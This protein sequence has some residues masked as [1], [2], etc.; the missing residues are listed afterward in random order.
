LSRLLIVLGCGML[1]WQVGS[2]FEPHA[3]Q[4][5]V[6]VHQPMVDFAF[7]PPEVVVPTGATVVWPNHGATIH[8]VAPVDLD[9]SSPILEPGEAFAFAFTAPGLY[10]VLCTIHPEMRAS[11]RVQ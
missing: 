9:W 3:A 1:G 6:V 4:A 11:V 8:T 5:Q 7:E 2:L 10:P